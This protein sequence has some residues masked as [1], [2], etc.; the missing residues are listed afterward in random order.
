MAGEEELEGVS[1]GHEDEPLLPQT[2][3][4][5]AVTS[6]RQR[7]CTQH[8]GLVVATLLAMV[9][10][11]SAVINLCFSNGPDAGTSHIGGVIEALSLPEHEQSDFYIFTHLS[12]PSKLDYY[13]SHPL[14][15]L[16]SSYS[17]K[18]ILVMYVMPKMEWALMLGYVSEVAKNPKLPMPR[19]LKDLHHKCRQWMEKVCQ[20]CNKTQT[21][22]RMRILTPLDFKDMLLSMKYRLGEDEFST[23]FGHTTYD[24]PKLID[25]IMRLRALGNAL[26]VLRFDINVLCNAHTKSDMSTIYSAVLRGL[27]DFRKSVEDPFVQEFVLSQQYV[28]VP[29]T[30]TKDFMAWN[31]AFSTHCGPALLA[32]PALCNASQ[33]KFD[34]SPGNHTCKLGD[35]DDAV[36]EATMMAFY[37]LQHVEGEDL[38]QPVLPSTAG[39]DEKRR[40][41]D[42]LRLGNAYIGANPSRAV[43]SGA[44]FATGP[45][46]TLDMPPF[47]HTD[48]NIMWI[49][50][51]LLDRLTQEVD[52]NKR[53][54]RPEG[55]GQARVVKAR[56]PPHNV[57][58]H[59]L[60]VD[61]PTLLYGIVMDA[62]VNNQP[63]GYLLKY[64]PAD[65]AGNPKVQ[66]AYASVIGGD[67]GTA[68]AKGTFSSA[69]KEARTTGNLAAER[70]VQFCEDLW[71]D[72]LTRMQDVYWQW[73]NLP[74]PKL[75]GKHQPTFA[76]LWAAGRVCEHAHLTNYCEN[77]DFEQLGRGMVIPSWDVEAREAES[78]AKLP[79]LEKKD[80][81]P[82]FA[83]KID[84]LIRA[85]TRH[86]EWVLLWPEVVQ[87]I[88]SASAGL[89]PSD[90]TWGFSDERHSPR[91]PREEAAR[92]TTKSTQQSANA[93]K[94]NSSGHRSNA[95]RA[96]ANHSHHAAANHS[97]HAAVNDTDR[98]SKTINATRKK[99]SAKHDPDEV[100]MET[101]ADIRRADLREK[102]RPES[103][104]ITP[105]CFN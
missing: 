63:D 102:M 20:E 47:L 60:E 62:W 56:D 96:A 15:E 93:T 6:A 100:F 50:D 16:V 90:V 57:A 7:L 65:L 5:A 13:L 74:A 89:A 49:D 34:G 12:D 70:I 79:F 44:A 58:K 95:T 73:I 98:R 43:I 86:L 22:D 94:K 78:R 54:P 75:H 36:D 40:E 76:T 25:S 3:A 23:W 48:L 72:A 46:V 82:A 31:E 87:A 2:A 39:T 68:T 103:E 27:E 30:K 88:R 14:M 77:E 71:A 9:S 8:T 35:L 83:A 26:P 53:R 52:G 51:H 41:E 32:T 4:V 80:L 69:V 104:C 99:A 10:A 28:G 38:L 55:V 37:G 64:G 18:G 92:E 42:I 29:V 11:A 61:I 84:E 91:L 97:H 45:G 59:T 66:D 105:P 33:W 19:E 17:L 101:L 81:N 24:A 85:A 21:P 67:G 1:S